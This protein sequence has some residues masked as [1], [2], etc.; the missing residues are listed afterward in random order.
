[1][2]HECRV[3]LA[4]IV[5]AVTMVQLGTAP[6]GAQSGTAS[7]SG[8]VEDPQG[9]VVPGATVTLVQTATGASRT[10]ATTVGFR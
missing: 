8:R 5:F 4:V 2:K 6:I 7:I 3:A 9:A 10:A 1:M